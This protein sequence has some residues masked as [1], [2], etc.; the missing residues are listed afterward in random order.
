MLK[1]GF[2]IDEDDPVFVDDCL[3]TFFFETL[4][5]LDFRTFTDAMLK[6]F[7]EF[8]LHINSTYGQVE[9]LALGEFKVHTHKLIGIESL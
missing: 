3:E 4:L 1:K 5:Q 8:F 9:T 6:C 7:W 2:A